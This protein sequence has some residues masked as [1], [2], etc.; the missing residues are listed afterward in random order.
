[1]CGISLTSEFTPT[2][3]VWPSCGACSS[4]P[5]AMRA[6]R[7][8]LGVDHRRAAQLFGQ[9][10]GHQ[11]RDDV[12]AA[13]GRAGHDQAHRSCSG[14][15][16]AR[17]PAPWQPREAE[18][19]RQ[20]GWMHPAPQSIGFMFSFLCLLFCSGEPAQSAP[21]PARRETPFHPTSAAPA[22]GPRV[23]SSLNCVFMPM[24]AIAAT[25]HQ[26]EMSLPASGSGVGIQPVLL[27]ATS[28]AKATANQGSSGGRGPPVRLAGARACTSPR[29]RSPAAAS[30]RA[31][32]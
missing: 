21:A 29:T 32:A 11:A 30:P 24:P 6:A 25:R 23:A 17:G 8:G 3:S 13:A 26:R 31:S 22:S 20:R 9:R 27:M 2:S 15:C 10:V 7:A 12:G 19:G 16:A 28:T 14:H 5:T 1:M 4:S 18:A